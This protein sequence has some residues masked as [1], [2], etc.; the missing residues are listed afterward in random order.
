[1]TSI[2][3]VCHFFSPDYEGGDECR[4]TELDHSDT[5]SFS[6]RKNAEAYAK[7]MGEGYVVTEVAL[8]QAADA[9]AA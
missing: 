7:E 5:K 6:Y 3:L 1:M 9:D 8:S 2:F 4:Y